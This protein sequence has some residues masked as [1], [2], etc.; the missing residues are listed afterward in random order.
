MKHRITIILLGLVL[1]CPMGYALPLHRVIVACDTNPIYLPYWP[2]VAQAWKKIVGLKPTLVII[3]PK[4]TPV[5]KT[6]GDV[7]IV[8]PL[9][10][11]PTALHAQ[12]IRMLIPFLFPND[13]CIV[14]DMDMFPLSKDYFVNSIA[15]VPDNSFV[16]YRDAVHRGE[17]PGMYPMCYIA[18]KGSVFQE[19]FNVHSLDDIAAIT[20]A[21]WA[22]RI[23]WHTDQQM[24]YECLHAW[25]DFEIRCIRLGHMVGPRVDRGAWHYDINLL[26]QGHY[27]DCHGFRPYEL[28]LHLL[29]QLVKDVG[30]QLGK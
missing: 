12:L 7:I 18:A 1:V 16:V 20:R 24:L 19:V 13:G 2:V 6:L 11:V 30:L 29:T 17:N 25:K 15:H 8:E 14:S 10:D 3:G 22:K 5:D 28:N 26:K 4:D 23:G 9:L 21:W 27:I